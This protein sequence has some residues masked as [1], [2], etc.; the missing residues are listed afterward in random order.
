MS[1]GNKIS[2][3]I[4]IL[5]A[6]AVHGAL[7]AL[8]FKN[9]EPVEATFKSVSFVLVD[10]VPAQSQ[11]TGP[12]S[13]PLSEPVENNEPTPE[14][15]PEPEPDPKPEPDPE[16]RPTPDPIPE[17]ETEPVPIHK[18]EPEP[19]PEEKQ[20]QY[21]QP[22]PVSKHPVQESITPPDLPG[23]VQKD[24]L[25]AGPVQTAF[26]EPEGPR[27]KQRVIPEYPMRARRMGREG[28]VGLKLHIDEQG[29]LVQAEIIEKAG[30]GLDEA[31]LK[32]VQQSTYYPASRN[33]Q[34]VESRARLNIRFELR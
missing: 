9:Q 31:A 34:P 21:A 18:P 20:T 5:L 17:P 13:E 12:K 23:P 24:P 10:P 22:E 11:Q 3:W 16:P 15:L 2:I 30:Y 4:S 26:G 1:H 14:P 6:F 27:F 28:V 8:P 33:G 29:N 25:P 32:A 7:F 19:K